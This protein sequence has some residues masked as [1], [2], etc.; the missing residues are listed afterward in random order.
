MGVSAQ[1]TTN[2]MFIPCFGNNINQKM[3][4]D[5]AFDVLDLNVEYSL[6]TN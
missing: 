3:K 5:F 4:K 2:Y 6:M 1:L